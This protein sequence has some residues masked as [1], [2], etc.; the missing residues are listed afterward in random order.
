MQ[1]KIENKVYWEYT[2]IESN[3][4]LNWQT[5]SFCFS[6][7]RKFIADAFLLPAQTAVERKKYPGKR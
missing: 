7:T 5:I 3:K 1:K 6:D 2:D 4:C